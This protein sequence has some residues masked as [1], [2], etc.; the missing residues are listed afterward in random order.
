MSLLLVGRSDASVDF[1]QLLL[2]VPR[3]QLDQEL[4]KINPAWPPRDRVR[5][6]AA[7]AYQALAE[8]RRQASASS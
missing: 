8:A 2:P 7:A 4:Q 6:A 5:S 3:P 1:L